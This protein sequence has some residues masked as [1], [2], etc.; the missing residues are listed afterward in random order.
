[1]S[2]AA[3]PKL[4]YI[5]GPAAVGKMT[6]GQRLAELTGFKLLYNHMVVDLVT[7]FFPFGSPPFH[8]LARPMTLQLIEACA[9]NDVSLIITHGLVFS[10]PGS[11]RL[12]EEWSAPYRRSGGEIFYAELTARLDV[13][14]ERNATE[15]RARHKKVDW[16][17]PERL[18]EM[19]GWGRWNSDGDIPDP[20][21][22][23]MINNTAI[24][25]EDA[26]ARIKD[27]FAL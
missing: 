13:R 24:G 21:R 8:A 19:E 1:V 3:A 15:N 6:V 10:A 12:L 17:T 14:I 27:A 9:A 26:A 25:A 7:A 11:H 5:L 23:V 18:R 2:D 20:S 16:A 22:H 4:V